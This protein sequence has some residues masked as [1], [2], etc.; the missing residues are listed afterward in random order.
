MDETGS[1][2]REFIDDSVST[3]VTTEISSIKDKIISKLKLQSDESEILENL[4]PSEIQIPAR[5][6]LINKNLT[7]FQK[8]PL[9]WRISDP[10]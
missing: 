8:W 10:C 9:L 6:N 1:N 2:I 7:N 3:I 4:F 5:K